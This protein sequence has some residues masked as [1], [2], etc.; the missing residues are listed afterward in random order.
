MANYYLSKDYKHKNINDAGNK[1][2]LDIEQIMEKI[3][4]YPLGKRRTISKNRILH[5]I[6]TIT[7]VLQIPIRIQKHDILI[8]QYPTRYYDTI[9]KLV[10]L[11]GAHI[12]TLIHDLNCFRQKHSSIEKEIC[13]L[14]RSDVLI[15]HN[16]SYSN[17]IKSNGFI[18]HNKRGI[19]I[20][21]HIFDFL[22]KSE[23]PNRKKTWPT[24]KIVYAGQLA[25]RKNRFL[26]I[27][28]KFIKE[29]SVNIY[30]KGFDKS[31]AVS[32]EKF[33]TKGF[34]LPEKL[35]CHS[36]GDF[37]LVWDGESIDC[38]S[39]NWGEYL[40]LNAPHKVSLY[41]RCGLPIIIWRKAAMAK[42]I[43]ENGIGI[44]IDSLREINNI[45]Q[46][47]TQNEYYKMCTNVS[48]VSLLMSKGHYFNKAVSEAILQIRDFQK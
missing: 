48:R 28:G 27:W 6:R 11:C 7:F 30:G 35:I 1:A 20:P 8:I 5:F 2:R 26:Y 12:I 9:C 18:G 47:L 10:H 42:F 13:R 39:G 23:S 17:W 32:P 22:S 25:L 21:L 38:C 29:Y 3:D 41:I 34:M 36:E 4:I 14:N 19:S 33:D 24:H 37:G 44:C 40:K 31:N 16:F 15:S 45:Y 46:S 43:E